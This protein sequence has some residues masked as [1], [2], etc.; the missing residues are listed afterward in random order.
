MD[1]YV[2]LARAGKR[3]K[4]RKAKRARLGLHHKV[5]KEDA[6]KWFE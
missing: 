3:V 4:Y 1:F 6:I 2:V 5:T